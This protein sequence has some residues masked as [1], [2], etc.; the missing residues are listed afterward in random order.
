MSRMSK[1][2]LLLSLLALTA[3][4]FHLRRN[5]SLPP[6]MQR[7]HVT[8]TGD[9]QRSLSR[10]L[11][12][13]G[14]TVEDHAGAGIAEL[15]IPVAAF[16]VDTLTVGGDARVTEFAVHYNVQFSVND[17]NALPI[18][19]PQTINMSREFSYDAFNTI[20]NQSQ[21][22]EIERSLVDDMVQAILFRLQA[23]TKHMQQAPASSNN[24]PAPASSTH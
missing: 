13:S 15:N 18:L 21:I 1:A 20:G 14:I 5:A 9:L 2:L 11:A 23:A 3:C 4:G 6:S 16:S 10:T 24:A 8:G 22:D 7:V 19:P 12:S 17:M